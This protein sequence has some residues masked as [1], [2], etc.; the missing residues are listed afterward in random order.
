MKKITLNHY[1]Q[2]R[3]KVTVIMVSYTRVNALLCKLQLTFPAVSSTHVFQ[4]MRI[5]YFTCWKNRHPH[6]HHKSLGCK[7]W[8][9]NILTVSLLV[10]AQIHIGKEYGI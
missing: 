2:S 4:M 1:S 10:T 6:I 9:I 7:L 8:Q 3:T 5:N